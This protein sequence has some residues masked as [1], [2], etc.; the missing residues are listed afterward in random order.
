MDPDKLM[1]TLSKE[2]QKTLEA[3]AKTKDLEEKKMYSEIVHNLSQ[4]LGVFLK[5]ASDMMGLDF[6]EL[7]G[8]D[9]N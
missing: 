3:M 7:D 2:L 5:L 6:D 4:S 8:Y 1:E 9:E